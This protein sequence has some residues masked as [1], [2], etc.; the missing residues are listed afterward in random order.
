ML[1]VLR[2]FRVVVNAIRRHYAE[3]E[4][5]TDVSGAQIWALA[6]VENHPGITVGQLASALAIHMSTAS[7]LTRKLESRGLLER[8]RSR[9]DQR[10]VR[11]SVS[12]AGRA[13]L[14][15]APQPTVG[16][17]QRAL[18]DLPEPRLVELHSALDALIRRLPAKSA[19]AKGVPLSDM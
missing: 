19:R 3:V 5:R 13:T 4:R 16:V 1:T 7:N 9:L 2:Q 8:S 17:L 11:M 10:S 18:M 12:N 6:Y 15:R 14:R